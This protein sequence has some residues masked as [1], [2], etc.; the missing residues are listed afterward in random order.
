MKDVVFLFGAGASYGAGSILPEAPPLGSQLYRVLRS[1]HPGTWGGLPTEI[2][3][4]FESDFE[5]GMAIV[6]D[7]FGHAI[8][9]LMREMALFFIQFR[10]YRRSSLY[11][12]LIDDLEGRGLLRRSLFSTL[13]Y[14][15]VLEFSLAE[16]GVPISYSESESTSEVPIW[17]LHGSANMF[18][19]G[20]QAG[21]GISY[22][23]GVVWEGGIQA[24]P[25]QERVVRH[26]LV[27]TGLAPVMCL[28]MKGKI[29]AVSPS[30]ILRLR[31]LWADRVAAAAVVV[32]VGV[33]PVPDDTHI[34]DPISETKAP[35]LFI[36]DGD[37]LQRWA[38]G[39]GKVRYEHIGERFDEAYYPLL[40]R[41]GEHA[42]Q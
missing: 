30:Q 11:C 14:D 22:G 18:S 41:L 34:W 24:L 38:S 6:Y 23:P 4:V 17:K 13:N 25:D 31:E 1:I 39:V 16:K 42:N 10:P 33:N 8:P 21:P 27:E 15:C 28:Y 3:E 35:L 19:A 20:I 26:C 2:Q 12:R 7:R 32:C 9:L 40:K 29:L 36:G 37:A 5:E